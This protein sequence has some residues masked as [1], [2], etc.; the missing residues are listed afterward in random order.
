MRNTYQTKQKEKI[1]SFVKQQEKEFTMM[2]LYQSLEKKIGLTT[3]YRL[4]DQLILDGVVVKTTKDSY[5]YLGNCPEENHFYLKCVNCGQ[6]IHVDC[7]FVEELSSHF[8]LEH[9]FHLKKEQLILQGVCSKCWEE[10]K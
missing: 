6:V 9:Q 3:I 5:Q 1:L 4:I 8:F 7:Q 2:E 10:K